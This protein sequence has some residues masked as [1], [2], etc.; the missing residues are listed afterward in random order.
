MLLCTEFAFPS[1]SY[2]KRLLVMKLAI[3][4]LALSVVVAG[5]V[6]AAVTPTPTHFVPSQLSATAAFPI[7]QCG[8]GVPT[9]PQQ[10]PP[11]SK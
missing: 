4:V 8:P 6:A 1:E 3:R 2:R 9:C 10:P 5:G 7:P 11:P